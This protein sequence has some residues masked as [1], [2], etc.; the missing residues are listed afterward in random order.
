MSIRKS[1]RLAAKAAKVFEPRRSVRIAQARAQQEH[2]EM[3]AA[4]PAIDTVEQ[5]YYTD[6]DAFFE[7]DMDIMIRNKFI[8]NLYI[9]RGDF[10]P[11][12]D[13]I[14]TYDDI[15]A[16]LINIDGKSY[17]LFCGMILELKDDLDDIGDVWS[18]SISMT[19]YM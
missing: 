1:P 2:T 15:H 11:C 12:K 8:K 13:I 3:A 10:Q 7:P 9:Q 4:L 5:L 14:L 18:D 19:K 16:I 17:W 6:R